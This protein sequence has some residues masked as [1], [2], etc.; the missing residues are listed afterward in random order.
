MRTIREKTQVVRQFLQEAQ[1]L[2]VKYAYSKEKVKGEDFI[3]Y[4]HYGSPVFSRGLGNR[5]IS[6]RAAYIVTV[7][8]GTARENLIYSEMIKLATNGTAIEFISES[9]TTTP[10][11]KG[12]HI[13][14]ILLYFYN[15]VDLML[16]T[17][18]VVMAE[19]EKNT[20]EKSQLMKQFLEI[21]QP[22]KVK[23]GY[24]SSIQAE[25]N[26]VAYQNIGSGMVTKGIGNQLISEDITF[27]VTVQTATARENMI[28]SEMIKLATERSQVRF[29]SEDKQH[30][31]EVKGSY[32]NNIILR[33]FGKVSPESLTYS[34]KDI[35]QALQA[36]ASRY[37]KVMEHYGIDIKGILV[38]AKDVQPEEGIYNTETL[39]EIKRNFLDSLVSPEELVSIH[40]MKNP[41]QKSMLVKQFL[42]MVQ[43]LAVKYG[44]VRGITRET[45]FITYQDLGIDNIRTGIGNTL[46]SDTTTF[47][48]TVQTMTAEQNMFFSEMIKL[49]TQGTEIQLISE[50]LREDT[51][52]QSGYIN[53]LIVNVFNTL[54]AH[55]TIYT[56]SE[57]RDILQKV[58]DNYIFITSIYRWTL[59]QSFIDKLIVPELEDRLYSYEEMLAMKQEYLDRLLLTVTKY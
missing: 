47:V 14:N 59:A 13:N 50:G 18:P 45:N 15:M 48:I 53:T 5:I 31:T 33:M 28:Y 44:Y 46:I 1:P 26:V 2:P 40:S 35:S 32:T 30:N 23:Y 38:S 37:A 3:S 12:K 4:R 56:A 11:V 10:T 8:T 17:T 22:L 42:E 58:A 49:G 51:T 43:P 19:E 20:V 36:I 25:P 52:V 39:I 27:V 9:R 16:N 21:A 29:I 54:E 24:D 57:V 55:K 7:Q 41:V 34:A 6:E